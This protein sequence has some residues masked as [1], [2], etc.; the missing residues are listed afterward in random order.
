MIIKL[1]WPKCDLVNREWGADEIDSYWVECTFEEA[2]QKIYPRL[3]EEKIQESKGYWDLR[4]REG[5]VMFKNTLLNFLISKDLRSIEPFPS[6]Y[7]YSS[8]WGGECPFVEVEEVN[9]SDLTE[10]PSLTPTMIINWG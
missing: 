4:L 7:P 10:I 1:M 5:N 9:I 3:T 2:D 8:Q 6:F